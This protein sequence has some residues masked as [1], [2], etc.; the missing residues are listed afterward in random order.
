[1]TKCEIMMHVL[2]IFFF[3]FKPCG[4]LPTTCGPY[5][6]PSSTLSNEPKLSSS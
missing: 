5:A 3:F 1:M 2:K 4:E 6:K